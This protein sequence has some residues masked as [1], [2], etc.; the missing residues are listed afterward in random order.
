MAQRWIN[1]I[2]PKAIRGMPR[3]GLGHLSHTISQWYATGYVKYVVANE[4]DYIAREIVEPPE[5]VDNVIIGYRSDQPW[6]PKT[7]LSA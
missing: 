5:F 7:F 3:K 6:N 2:F 1:Q 4:K